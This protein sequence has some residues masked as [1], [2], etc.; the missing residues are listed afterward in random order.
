MN[1]LSREEEMGSYRDRGEKGRGES[2]EA[3]TAQVGE[4]CAPSKSPGA[5]LVV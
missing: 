3:E 4:S 5:A 1:Y 2:S